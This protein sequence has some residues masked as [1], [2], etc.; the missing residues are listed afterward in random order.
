VVAEAA[1]ADEG[2][3]SDV[4]VHADQPLIASMTDTPKKATVRL[5]SRAIERSQ[6]SISSTH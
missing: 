2:A 4:D 6:G 5:P 1:A 3:F